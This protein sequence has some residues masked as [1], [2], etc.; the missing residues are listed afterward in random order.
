MA[1]RVALVLMVVVMSGGIGRARG[2]EIAA[3]V[4][5]AEITPPRGYRMAGYFSE[6]VNTGVRDPLQAK[7]IVFRQGPEQAALVFCDVVSIP[8]EVA[9][10]AREEASR[11]TGI[12][13]DRIAVAATHS[14]TGPLFH[15]VLRS[16]F[17]SDAVAAKGKDEAEAV[18]YPALLAERVADAVES[19]QK[20]A[21]PMRLSVGVG[22]QEGI[23]FNR[24]FHMKDGSVR[25]NPGA[26][27]PAVVEAAG[28]IDPEV[29]I[30]FLRPETS[31][32]PAVGLSVFAL[33]LDTVGGSE[34]SADYPYYLQE[35]LRKQFGPGFF[36]LF[37]T[38]TCGD[39][40]HV[41]VTKRERLK[42]DI[43]GRTLARTV[44]G[45]ASALAPIKEPSLAVASAVI[46]LPVQ[47]FSTEEVSEARRVVNNFEKTRPPFLEIVRACKIVDLADNY[48]EPSTKLEVQAFRISPELAIVTL[49]GEVFVELGQ[50]IKKASP[51]PHTF[52][53]ELTNG[54]PAY[55]PTK[56]A[57]QEGSYEVVNSRLAP[58]GGEALVATAI[59]LLRKVA[60]AAR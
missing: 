55:V 4:A 11:R 44:I 18:D 28:P 34:Y 25:T 51:F 50:A 13:A 5:A 6:R 38:G 9:T 19:A 33:H 32:T 37:G 43:I 10:R 17:H 24:R 60:P 39:I 41:D 42:T 45:E 46:E 47:H 56:K 35:E 49:P 21:A 26:L 20:S 14:H 58:G 7:A 53:V 23:S 16:R 12:P 31:E 15:G 57:Y 22:R 3:G 40:N 36:S 54:S 59:D 29:G 8:R 52:I 1:R 30:L 27:N 48:K 2:G